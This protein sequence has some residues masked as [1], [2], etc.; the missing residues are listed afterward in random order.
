[1]K[2]NEYHDE[3]IKAKTDKDLELIACWALDDNALTDS[4]YIAICKHIERKGKRISN[5]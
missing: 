5:S 4:E 3:I 1:M 2:I